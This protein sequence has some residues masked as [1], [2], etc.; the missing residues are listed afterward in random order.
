MYNIKWNNI[1]FND[2]DKD[3]PELFLDSI[4]GKYKKAIFTSD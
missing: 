3:M 1:Y 4:K 2:I